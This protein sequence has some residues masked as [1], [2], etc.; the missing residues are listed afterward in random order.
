M[1]TEETYKWIKELLDPEI[2]EIS[3][4]D[5]DRLVEDYFQK[6]K[7]DWYEGDSYRKTW[8]NKRVTQFWE[9]IR[10]FSMSIGKE[11]K[12]YDFNHFIFPS[13]QNYT[14]HDY[15]NDF[16][17]TNTRKLFPF[18]VNFEHATFLSHYNFN[19][20]I[21][22]DS[23]IFY[24]TIFNGFLSIES[25]EFKNDVIFHYS[26]I[27]G[28]EINKT[29]F[30]KKAEFRNCTCK[31]I[32]EIINTVFKSRVS[33][34]KSEF[35]QKV[36]FENASFL[37]FPNQFNESFFL[38]DVKFYECIF[39][40]KAQFMPTFFEKNA[41]F[42]RPEF[43]DKV[44]FNQ[45]EFQGITIFDRPIFKE[46]ADFSFCYFEDIN[47]KEINTIWPYRDTNYT[48]PPELYFKDVFFNSKTFIK[49]TDLSKLELDN[50]DVSNITF[51]RCVWNDEKNR[52]KLVNELPKLNIEIKNQLKLS[53]QSEAK[54]T[55]VENL[56]NKLRDSENHYR[57]LKK[58]FDTTKS[59]ELSGKAYVSE[60]EM[61]K[62][63]LWLEGSNYQWIIYKFYDVFG[64][65]TQDFRKPIVSLVGLILVFSGLYF[66]IDYD[67]LKALQRGIKGA[68]PYM[69][70][71]VENPF[72]GYWL[73]LRN[74]ELVLGGTFLA[75]FI[76][77]LR[78]RFKQ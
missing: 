38:D 5:Y 33:F 21:F 8:D 68:L 28:L 51:S 56:T 71:D 18:T 73:I 53:N 45:S 35:Q 17:E 12:I 40:N 64:G 30:L 6:D 75:F 43:H 47:F 72:K 20:V 50:S 4:E 27:K 31:G 70:I 29:Y 10:K 46:K 13:F 44:F 77:A 65:Y 63:R 25:S 7:T 62:Q 67:I 23:V 1:I 32:F 14:Y 76:L 19:N 41:E 24:G 49:N 36:T 60:M 59:W 61:R 78:K 54:K 57:Q 3:D 16:W 52:L 66:F 34:N 39:H 11:R 48:E 26:T 55:A 37:G 42:I 15:G 2:I 9:L 74:I 22:E 69:Q 58:N